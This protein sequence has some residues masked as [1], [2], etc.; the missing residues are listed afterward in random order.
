M[1]EEHT[2]LRRPGR[3][4]PAP[5]RAAATALSGHVTARCVGSPGAWGARGNALAVT[6]A[7]RAHKGRIA[8]LLAQLRRVSGVAVRLAVA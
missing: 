8:L 7:V 2:I 1:L 5:Q 4:V 6:I 3:A